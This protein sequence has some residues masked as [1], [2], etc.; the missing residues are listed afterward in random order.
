[1]KK[2]LAFFLSALILLTFAVSVSAESMTFD[3]GGTNKSSQLTINGTTATCKS[4]IIDIIGTVKTVTIEQTLEKHWA[5]GWFFGVDGASWK[6]TTSSKSVTYQ[7]TKT[8][9]SSGTY[10]VKSV[11]TVTTTSGQTETVTVYSAEKTIS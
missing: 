10:R 11:F 2:I 6:T 5:F 9:L 1:M 4:Q 7:N 8:G 3:V